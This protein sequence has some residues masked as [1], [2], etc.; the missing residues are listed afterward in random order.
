MK[1][2][3]WEKKRK[4]FTLILEQ[5]T[6]S[7]RAVLKGNDGCRIVKANQDAI[8]LLHKVKGLCNK[9]DPTKQNTHSIVTADKSIY[10]FWQKD[11]MDNASYFEQFNMLIDTADSY[12]CRMG[13]SKGLVDIKM[14]KMNTDHP[15]VTNDQ[16]R[17]AVDLAREAYLTMVMLDGANMTRFNGLRGELYNDDANGTDTY[18]TNQNSVLPL[19]NSRKCSGPIKQAWKQEESI[20]G[21]MF[22]Q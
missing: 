15:C 5:C 4:S 10:I 16:K 9:H 21:M 17:K 14:E 8:P 6:P 18:P 13:H 2:K 12:G 20:E 19:I 7:L 11:R 3:Y 1:A 22:A